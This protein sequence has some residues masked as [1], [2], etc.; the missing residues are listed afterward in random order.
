[1]LFARPQPTLQTAAV[2]DTYPQS[3][4]GATVVLS[5]GTLVGCWHLGILNS[6]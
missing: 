4:N 6:S 5:P 3:D 2:G 1:M